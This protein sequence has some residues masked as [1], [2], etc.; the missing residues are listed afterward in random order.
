MRVLNSYYLKLIAEGRMLVRKR[1][2]RSLACCQVRDRHGSAQSYQEATTP[3][4][5]VQDTRTRERPI[6]T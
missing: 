2:W 3:L 4:L 5:A 6:T 1:M